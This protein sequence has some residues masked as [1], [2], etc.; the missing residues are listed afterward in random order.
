MFVVAV[1]TM[2]WV[3][4]SQFETNIEVSKLKSACSVQPYIIKEM[5]ICYDKDCHIRKITPVNLCDNPK[6]NYKYFNAGR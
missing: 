1:W 3:A 5:P 2:F 4:A 6:V